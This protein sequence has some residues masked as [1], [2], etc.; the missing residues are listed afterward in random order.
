VGRGNPQ[1][2]ISLTRGR[3]EEKNPRGYAA[4]R[5]GHLRRVQSGDEK[6][7]L[8]KKKKT[9]K[10]RRAACVHQAKIKGKSDAYNDWEGGERNV[11]DQ[12]G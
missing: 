4:F 2:R 12:P 9:K 3:R 1:T 11:S 6:K 5:P 10:K 7:D 8:P